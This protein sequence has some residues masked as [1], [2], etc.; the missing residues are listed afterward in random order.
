LA[1]AGVNGIGEKAIAQAT[2]VTE[3]GQNQDSTKSQNDPDINTSSFSLIAGDQSIET[4]EEPMAQV[5]SV[6]QLQ[7]VQPTDWPFPALQSLVERYACI[8]GYP[9]GTFRGNRA[10]T[11]YEFAA[12]LNACLD[13]ITQILAIT[14]PEEQRFTREDLATLEKLQAEFSTELKTLRSRVDSLET[15]TAE[16]A[17]NQ[18]STTTKLFGTAIIGI[19]GRTSNRGD[20]N[21]RNGTQDLSDAGTNTT[22]ISYTRLDLVSYF[23]PRNYLRTSITSMN[24][25]TS[26]RFTNEVRGPNNDVILGYEYP[27]SQPL[28]SDLFYN[29]QVTDKFAVKV[30]TAGMDMINHFRGITP[31]GP[32]NGPVSRFAQRNPIIN[33]GFGQGGVAID[34]QIAK[35]ASLQALYSSNQSAS[36]NQGGGLFDGNTTAGVQLLVNP[37]QTVG[38]SLYYVNNYSRNGCLLTFVGDDCLT[39]TKNQGLLQTGNP[40]QTNAFGGSVNWQISPKVTLGGWGGYTTSEVPGLSGSVETTNYMVYLNFPDLFGRGNFGG[41]Y[42]GQPPKITSSS[43]PLGNIPDLIDGNDGT[44]S[45]GQPGTTTHIEAFYRLR[46]TDNISVTPGIIHLIEPGNTPNS[47]SVTIGVLR[48]TFLF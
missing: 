17:A 33:T 5:T 22:L 21:P 3:S 45:G 36:P 19:Q 46:L 14:A 4:I 24:G 47:D 7:D 27:A 29:W 9:D 37:V 8:A 2:N 1:I 38:L 28:L 10:L 32:P 40:L 48:T 42:V 30:G 11:R 16:I 23:T 35:N 43:L 18:F 15:R 12:G 20:V 39:G 31:Y 25:G 13:S 6:S 34:W 41:I 44:K 26:P